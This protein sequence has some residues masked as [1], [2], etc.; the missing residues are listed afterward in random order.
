MK[1][2]IIALFLSNISIS[3][4]TDISEF[5]RKD[6][7]G[8]NL[9]QKSTSIRKG[10]EKNDA[11][12]DDETY[13]FWKRHLGDASS[14]SYSTSKFSISIG[15]IIYPLITLMKKFQKFQVHHIML[16]HCHRS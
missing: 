15:Q 1:H 4:S 5:G 6:R 16:I 12:D 13:R 7:L 10:E 14:M 8:K 11:I 9:H 2:I 3:I